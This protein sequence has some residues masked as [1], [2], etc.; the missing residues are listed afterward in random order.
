MALSKS[1]TG[2]IIGDIV[3]N[4]AEEYGQNRLQPQDVLDYVNLAVLKVYNDIPK[5]LYQT[6]VTRTV[7]SGYID[8]SDLIVEKIEKIT[9]TANGIWIPAGIDEIE[10]FADNTRRQNNVYYS[11]E[12]QR[13]KVYKGDNTSAYGTISMLYEREIVLCDD[14]TDFIDVPDK[15]APA[16]ME[17]AKAITHEKLKVATVKESKV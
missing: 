8:L 14:E 9:D 7:S 11:H 12:G 4:V 5:F 17:I 16:V 2:K 1:Y 6:P 3:R 10:N 15:Y 13:V